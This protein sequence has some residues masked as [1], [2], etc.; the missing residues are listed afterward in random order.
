MQKLADDFLDKIENTT[1][2]SS[3]AIIVLDFSNDMGL[4]ARIREE[5]VIQRRDIPQEIMRS[6]DRRYTHL[7]VL[8]PAASRRVMTDDEIKNYVGADNLS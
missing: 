7:S 3:D 8:C 2:E 6:L 4:L 1:L 5:A